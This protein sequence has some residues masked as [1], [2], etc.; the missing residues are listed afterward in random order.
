MFL[1]QLISPVV[2]GIAP[3]DKVPVSKETVSTATQFSAEELLPVTKPILL[4]CAG[5]QGA[6]DGGAARPAGTPVPTGDVAMPLDEHLSQATR[7]EILCG[8]FID[9]FLGFIGR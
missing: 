3:L 4:W 8:D 2:A 6:G 5:S 1:S 9:V 7:D